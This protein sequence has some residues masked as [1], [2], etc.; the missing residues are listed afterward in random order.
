MLVSKSNIKNGYLSENGVNALGLYYVAR[1]E[2]FDS[3]EKIPI[4]LLSLNM[5]KKTGAA[6]PVPV[7][8]GEIRPVY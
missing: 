6:S 7:F 3:V 2:H 5:L 8:Q 4:C 1:L